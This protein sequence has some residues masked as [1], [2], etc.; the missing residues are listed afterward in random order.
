MT[1]TEAKYENTIID[2]FQNTLHYT[3][4]QSS[5]IERDYTDPLYMDELLPALRRIN[6]TL[7]EVALNEA[8][9]KLRGLEGG[10]LLQKNMDFMHYLQTGVTVRFHNN[11]EEQDVLVCLVDYQ[12][13]RN[14]Q[15]QYARKNYHRRR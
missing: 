2:L 15:R 5:D 3:H 12:N 8:I 1:F 4:V 11:I 14:N 13:E 6:P 10:N 7:P 9:Y